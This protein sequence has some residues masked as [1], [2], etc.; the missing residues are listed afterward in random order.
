MYTGVLRRRRNTVAGA[1][2]VIVVAPG[3][4]PRSEQAAEIRGSA[5]GT[6]GPGITGLSP[7][8][9]APLHAYPNSWLMVHSSRPRALTAGRTVVVKVVVTV[10]VLETEC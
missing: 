2:T 5:N 10:D 9:V 7:R 3:V 8:L 4:T 1:V 6:K